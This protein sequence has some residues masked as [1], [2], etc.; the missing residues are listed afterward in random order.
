MKR[1]SAKLETSLDPK[2]LRETYTYAWI[3]RIGSVTL[4]KITE[5]EI[6]PEELLEAR[7]FSTEKELHVYW[8]NDSLWTTETTKE[9]SDSL[10]ETDSQGEKYRQEG[11]HYFEETHVVRGKGTPKL[12]LRH[13]IEHDEDGLAYIGHTVLCDY[14]EK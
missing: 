12:T 9:E 3:Q 13:F 11:C 6:I 5:E 14:K 8:H 4:G 2:E 1:I 7:F 10:L